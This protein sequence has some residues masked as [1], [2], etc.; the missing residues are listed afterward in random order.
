MF[1]LRTVR[2]A[3]LHPVPRQGVFVVLGTLTALP[4]RTPRGGVAS[5]GPPSGIGM[6]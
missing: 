1:E 5:R 3:V 4:A 6:S 2:L